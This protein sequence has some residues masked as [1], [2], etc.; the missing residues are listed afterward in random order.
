MSNQWWDFFD[1]QCGVFNSEACGVRTEIKLEKT[2]L[3]KF[4]RRVNSKGLSA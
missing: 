3:L 4:Y 2:F 1:I